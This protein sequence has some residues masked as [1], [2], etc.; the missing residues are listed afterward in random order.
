LSGGDGRKLLNI[1]ELVIHLR[2]FGHTIV[3]L[4]MKLVMQKIQKNT[5]THVKLGATL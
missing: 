2:K 1:F 5:V 4:R 3:D